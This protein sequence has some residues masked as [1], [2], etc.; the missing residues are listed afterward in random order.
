MDCRVDDFPLSFP[1]GESSIRSKL[2]AYI[3]TAGVHMKKEK[4]AEILLEV[5]SYWLRDQQIQPAIEVLVSYVKSGKRVSS[6]GRA[7]RDQ[8]SPVRR[9]FSHNFYFLLLQQTPRALSMSIKG[10]GQVPAL[11]KVSTG[12]FFNSLS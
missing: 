2:L 11:K 7:S 5:L 8:K 10:H 1:C 3:E 12:L 4:A 9:S 6:V